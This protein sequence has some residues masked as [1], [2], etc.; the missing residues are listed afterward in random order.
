[1]R[2][3]Q[4]SA[5]HLVIVVVLHVLDAGRV[6]EHRGSLASSQPRTVGFLMKRGT[7][8]EIYSLKALMITLSV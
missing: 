4:I 2:H 6:E 5:T 1:M 7:T 8:W 3:I